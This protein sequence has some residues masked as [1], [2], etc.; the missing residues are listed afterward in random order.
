MWELVIPT[1]LFV[2][3]VDRRAVIGSTPVDAFTFYASRSEGSEKL[4]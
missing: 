2:L 1:A 3:G 4:C